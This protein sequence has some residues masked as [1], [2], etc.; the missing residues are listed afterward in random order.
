MGGMWA[1]VGSV[2]RQS[3]PPPSP[4]T[5][6]PLMTLLP[7]PSLHTFPPGP[8]PLI[9]QSDQQIKGTLSITG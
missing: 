9:K 5:P 6:L 1:T 8:L 3:Q 2:A 7:F 4:L